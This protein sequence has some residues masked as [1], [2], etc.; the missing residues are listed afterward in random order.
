MK[1]IVNILH[2]IADS[3]LFFFLCGLVPF[4]LLFY[5]KRKTYSKEKMAILFL[6]SGK[7]IKPPSI[8][9]KKYMKEWH[10]YFQKQFLRPGYQE[11]FVYYAGEFESEVY[12][13]TKNVKGVVQKLLDDQE[14]FKKTKRVI[15]FLKCYFFV[16]NL[17]DNQN[18]TAISAY[19]PSDQLFLAALLRIFK[20]IPL[21]IAVMGNGDL[22]RSEYP[23]KFGKM[24]KF[25]LYVLE[26]VIAELAFHQA[27]LVMAYNNHCGDFA[28]CNG[29]DAK[30]IRR[31]RIYPC[32][33]PINKSHIISQNDLDKFPKTK[34]TIITW[35]RFSYEKKLPF[36]LTGAFKALA[37]DQ[38]LGLCII[39]YGPMAAEIEIL[40]KDSGVTERI[41][42]PGFIPSHQ[43]MS[44]IFHSD[45][46]LIP[47][48][49]FAL[50]EAA[51][52]K[53]AIV[54]FDIEWHHELLTDGYS[55]YF[56]DY[57]NSDQICAQILEAINDPI[58]AKKRGERAYKRYK[59]LFDEEKIYKREQQIMG[60]FFERM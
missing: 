46:A 55:G 51:M 8:E 30:K 40:V 28:L 17:I 18:I 57:P 33:K 27:D 44:Y 7:P 23:F 34:K 48:G 2:G 31:T 36:A 12:Q 35:S 19:A 59:L 20:K 56:A 38:D 5:K 39:G 32:V 29:A 1:K 4:I 10:E 16:V 15:N 24:K 14:I 60:E 54:C 43:L 25:I 26:K 37:A 21:I 49:G 50:L 45:V 58:E 6:A 11:T 41:F 42:M 9:D 52:L 53:K 47:L 3:I 13:L 22:S